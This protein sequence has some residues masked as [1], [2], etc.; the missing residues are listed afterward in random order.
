MRRFLCTALIVLMALPVSGQT[1]KAGMQKKL[2]KVQNEIAELDRQ[3]KANEAKSS[4]ALAQLTLTRKKIAAGKELAAELGRQIDS[5]GRRIEAKKKDIAQASD[6]Y[7]M[8]LG[9]YEM[10]IRRAYVNRDTKMW[11]TY[12]FAG[13]D[14]GQVFRRYN[15]LRNISGDMRA[16][17]RD[18]RDQKALMEREMSALDSLKEASEALLATRSSELKALQADE[19]SEKAMVAKLKK[20]KADYQK[21]LARKQKEADALNKSIRDFVAKQSAGKSSGKKGTTT[22]KSSPRS[23]ADIK[24]SNEFAG[25]KG[26]LPWPVQGTIVGQF[27]QHNHPVYTNVKL[28]FNNGCNIATSAGAPVKAVFAGT[29][30]NVVV[31]PG[32]NQC[33]LVQHGDYYTFYCK[34]KD[35]RVKTDD[36][37]ALGDVIGSVDTISGETQLH[38]QL[39]SGTTP[40]DPEKWLR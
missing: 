17:A 27:G 29:V 22:G 15:Y 39:W 34:L 35:V 6:R 30:K 5:T 24:L 8:M 18:I 33:V 37:V 3:I 26:K 20:G 11:L 2:T 28:P 16:Q 38:F 9:A 32:Y 10:L 13:K 31:L 21:Q 7:D 36:K 19:K 25:N 4:D 23:Q 14:L 12:I 1:T 40:Q